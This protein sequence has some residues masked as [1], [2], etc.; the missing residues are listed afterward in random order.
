MHQIAYFAH[1]GDEHED[2][3]SK[4]LNDKFCAQIMYKYRCLE[5]PGHGVGSG[6]R[7]AER[8]DV[9]AP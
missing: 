2:S 5:K 7:L 4:W 8:V 1:L 3:I 6:K 9:I